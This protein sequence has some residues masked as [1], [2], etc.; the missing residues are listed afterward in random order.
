MPKRRPPIPATGKKQRTPQD[1]K[2]RPQV[3]LLRGA[4]R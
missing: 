1:K 2:K 3:K 4:N